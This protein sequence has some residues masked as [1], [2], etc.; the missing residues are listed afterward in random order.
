MSLSVKYNDVELNQYIH[1]LKGFT[2]RIG[3]DWQPQ[4]LENSGKT[5]GSGF[6]YTTYKS[7]SIE[8]PLASKG[9]SK[10]VMICWKRF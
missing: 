8:M 2:P 4:V 6:Q 9:I 1:V 5:K 7:K 10:P 3:A